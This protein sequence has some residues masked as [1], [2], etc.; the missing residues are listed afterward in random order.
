MQNDKNI[1]ALGVMTYP[2]YL[3]GAHG[4]P[5]HYNKPPQ[6]TPLTHN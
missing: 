2:S 6:L 1:G 4:V 3:F 5:N